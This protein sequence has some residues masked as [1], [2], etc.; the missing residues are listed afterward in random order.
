MRGSRLLFFALGEHIALNS[1]MHFLFFDEILTLL[2]SLEREHAFI[3]SSAAAFCWLFQFGSSMPGL[4]LEID[5]LLVWWL[6]KSEQSFQLLIPTY[7]Y[8]KVPYEQ[9]LHETG[10]SP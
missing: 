2:V 6:Q 5:C 1:N 3:S 8:D 7:N 10:G 4:I 9:E